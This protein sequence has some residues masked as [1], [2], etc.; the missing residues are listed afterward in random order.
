MFNHITQPFI[1]KS[2]MKTATQNLSLVREAR[3]LLSNPKDTYI[4]ISCPKSAIARASC[5]RDSLKC[6][7]RRQ[8]YCSK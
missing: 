7:R 4:Y 3:N 1:M 5:E 6:L 2:N 8:N